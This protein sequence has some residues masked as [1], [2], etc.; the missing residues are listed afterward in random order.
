MNVISCCYSD[1]HNAAAVIP[2]M[3]IQGATYV[4]DKWIVN[5]ITTC[6][7]DCAV[8]TV[9]YDLVSLLYH[10]GTSAH[11]GHYITT[12][13]RQHDWIVCDDDK[14]CISL[15]VQQC[16]VSSDCRIT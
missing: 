1:S 13:R 8:Q 2:E 16:S 14:I 7:C 6:F 11:D 12:V 3:T 15:N 4:S 9:E 10:I 5:V